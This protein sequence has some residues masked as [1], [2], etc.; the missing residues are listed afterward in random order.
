MIDYVKFKRKNVI[1]CSKIL[2]NNYFINVNLFFA[3]NI[4]LNFQRR[5][6]LHKI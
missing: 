1:S 4:V 3:L 5:Y 2:Y 6:L